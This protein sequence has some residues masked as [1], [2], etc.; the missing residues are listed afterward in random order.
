M[1]VA[2]QS[3][4]PADLTLWEPAPTLLPEPWVELSDALARQAKG[5]PRP[6]IMEIKYDG[7]RVGALLRSWGLPWDVVMAGYLWEYDREEIQRHDLPGTEAVIRHM[8]YTTTYLGYIR[9]DILPPLLT[10]PFDDLGALLIAVAIYYETFRTLLAV[11]NN[12]PLHR[13]LRSEIERV[14]LTLISLTKRLGMWHFKRAIEDTTER[15]RNPLKFAEMKDEYER[16]LQRDKMML[17]DTQE[18]LINAYRTAACSEQIAVTYIPCGVVGLK[19]RSQDANIVQTPEKKQLSG[20]DLVTFEVIVPT[21]AECYTALGILSQLGLIEKVAD[22]IATPK[23]NGYSHIYLHLVINPRDLFTRDGRHPST[24]SYACEMQIATRTMQAITWYGGLFPDYYRIYTEPINKKTAALPSLES[25]WQSESG[26]VFATLY[27]N[28]TAQRQPGDNKTPIVVY[29]SKTRTPLALPKGATALDFAYTLDQSIGAHTVYAI[30]NNRK[31]PL[32]RILDADDIVEIVTSTEI[33]AQEMWLLP[34]HTTI[35]AVRKQV[36]KSLRDRTGYKLLRLELERYHYIIPPEA[37]EEQLSMLV[38]LHSLGTVHSYIERLQSGARRVFT[39]QWAAQQIMQQLAERNEYVPSSPDHARRIPVVDTEL[40][41]EKR[42]FPQQHF[43]SLCRP[44]Q[45]QDTKIMGRVRKRDN[46]LMVHTESCPSLLSGT[47][48][49]LLPM[50][51]QLQPPMFQVG[52]YITVQDRKGL[53]FD[54]T[55]QL[56]RYD[57][58]LLSLNAE[59]ITS[60]GRAHMRFTIGAH[61]DAEVLEILQALRKIDN[62]IA[63]DIDAAATSTQVHDRLQH[64][65]RQKKASPP[66]ELSEFLDEPIVLEPRS[67]RLENPFDI[68]RPATAPMFFGRSTETERMRRELCDQARG[69]AL[70]LYGPRRSGKTSI[71]TNFLERQVRPP[72]WGVHFSMQN[73]MMQN[74]ETILK[75]LT[76]VVSEQ[77]HKQLHQQPPV[78][79]DFSGSDVEDRFRKFLKSCIEGITGSRLILVLDEFGGAIESYQHHILEGRFFS[80]WRELMDALPQL[81]LVFV[82]PTASHKQLTS[83]EFA[84]SFSF[85]ET[86]P[87]RFLDATSARQLLVEPLREQNI[88]VSAGATALAVKLSGGNPYYMSLIGQELINCLNIVTD[89]Q[90]V[91]DKDLRSVSEQLILASAPQNFDFLRSELQEP[92]EAAILETIVDFTARTRETKMQ[93][94]QLASRLHL[95]PSIVQRHLDRL[96]AGLILDEVGRHPNTYYSF[97]IELIRK[98]LIHN[99]WFFT[100]KHRR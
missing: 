40:T 42:R 12:K 96:R 56:R 45:A 71:C 49:V 32:Y 50:T 95:S 58:D 64:I 7:Q 82:L 19:R 51:W 100:H 21:V 69:R 41:G 55:R 17:E 5:K 46:T 83:H 39:P 68:S 23:R 4:F 74:E 54:L 65:R 35:S 89:Q 67:F 15:L 97:K 59:P 60:Q 11:S 80:Y 27:G 30:V 47:P 61:S 31:S 18:W 22:R 2:E 1:D 98:W 8:L 52:F 88:H 93:L 81:S 57:C 87:L 6:Y 29:H 43:C 48:S 14:E 20:F 62:T 94:K 10:P 38:Q 44:D 75:K 3:S 84:N 99:R 37:L 70:I 85:A 91:T 63:I 76:A 16:I 25:L 53:L 78:W 90:I 13:T 36:R 77:Y 86:L 9:D 34:S 73:S 24:D 28:I 92:V 66:P 79:E 26:K 33:Q 72:S